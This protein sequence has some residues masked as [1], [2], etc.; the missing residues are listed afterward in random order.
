MSRPWPLSSPIDPDT[1]SGRA[2]ETEERKGLLPRE[3]RHRRLVMEG[4]DREGLD[5]YRDGLVERW[6]MLM[7]RHST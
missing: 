5:A 2:P 6:V 1:S 7:S 3:P 4:V